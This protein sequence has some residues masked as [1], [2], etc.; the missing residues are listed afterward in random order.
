MFRSPVFDNVIVTDLSSR[1]AGGATVAGAEATAVS[2]ATNGGGGRAA[3]GV[4][5]SL[6]GQDDRQRRTQLVRHRRAHRKDALQR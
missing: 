2:G 3:T 5:Q 4:T 6:A 1:A